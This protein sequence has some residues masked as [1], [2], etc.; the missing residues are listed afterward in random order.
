MLFIICSKDKLS[1]PPETATAT[2]SSCRSIEYLLI[3]FRVLSS[4]EDR[5]H[6]L[7]KISPE[8]CLQYTLFLFWHLM[9]DVC[10]MR[11]GAV[12]LNG[13]LLLVFLRIYMFISG[14]SNSNLERTDTD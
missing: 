6:F 10:N 1:L 5:K 11:T 9:Q 8:Y 12:E 4:I 7:H 13:R 14:V 2:L 3:V